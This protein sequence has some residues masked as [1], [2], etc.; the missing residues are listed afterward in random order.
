MIK[1]VLTSIVLIL[2]FVP[3]TIL[4]N[5]FY[6]SMVMAIAYLAGYELLNAFEK[7]NPN[8][9][10]LK[11]VMPL[12]NSYTVLTYFWAPEYFLGVIIFGIV[13]FMSLAILNKSFKMETVLSLV[14][15]YI[16]TGL[17]L[18]FALM[19]RKP[20]DGKEYIIDFSKDFY[21]FGMLVL[22]VC[23]TD[24]GA[25]VLGSLFGKRKLCPSISPNKTIGGAIGGLACG[26]IA[27]CVWYFF[28]KGFILKTSI[29][30]I[31][32]MN[33]VLEILI[34]VL[35]TA[36]VSICA[37]LGDLIASK[38]KRECGI[39]DYSNLLPGHGGILDRFDSI[40]FAG[41]VFYAICVLFF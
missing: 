19:L 25:F 14:F 23:A 27:G 13:V 1:R 12:W 15:T 28:F 33:I 17:L 35:F 36:V 39:K 34:L 26:I 31:Y 24:V 3:L 38:I 18:T 30:G 5:W 2:I 40:I 4:G 37:Q 9:H 21:L 7:K 11:Y 22:I 20:L 8:L 41:S 16:Y 10:R 29:L 32:D 6:T